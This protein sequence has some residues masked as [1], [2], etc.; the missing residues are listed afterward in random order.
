MGVVV[1]LIL[2]LV[3]AFLFIFY[4][5]PMLRQAAVPTQINVPD[6][7]DVNIQQK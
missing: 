2:V 4:G 7:I 5:L 1:S 6:K 3:I